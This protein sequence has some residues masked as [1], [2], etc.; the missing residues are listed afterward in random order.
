MNR[1]QALLEAEAEAIGVE[2]EAIGVEAVDEIAASTSLIVTLSPVFY[3]V[4]NISKK[5]E[6]SL[7]P[8]CLAPN[9]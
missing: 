5:R 7:E 1:V 8:Q 3:L 2:A 6:N 9:Q 4:L